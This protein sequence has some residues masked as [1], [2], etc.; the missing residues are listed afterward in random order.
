MEDKNIIQLFW[1]RSEQGL[2]ELHRKYG[3]FL[4]RVAMNILANREDSEECVNDTYLKTWDSIP[5]ASPDNLKAYTGKITRNIA[6]N[7]VKF[8]STEKRGKNV[9]LMLSELEDC[10]PSSDS[11]LDEYYA[12]ELATIINTYVNSLDEINQCIFV[13][14]Y[15]MGDPTT[16]IA[17]LT[18]L[19]ENTIN[20]KLFDMRKRLK[21]AIESAGHAVPYGKQSK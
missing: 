3:N 7:R 18:G 12:T 14:R 5:P 15:W 2:E 17:K 16:A 21:Q 20:W 13:R 4:Y 8:N 9:T 11:V 6:L 19:P 10:I 1:S